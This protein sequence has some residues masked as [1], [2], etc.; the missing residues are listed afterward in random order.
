M[1]DGFHKLFCTIAEAITFATL[2]VSLGKYSSDYYLIYF[3]FITVS[4]IF[5][6]E[7]HRYTV[8]ERANKALRILKSCS[9]STMSTRGKN[10][11]T[12][13]EQKNTTPHL[14][15]RKKQPRLTDTTKLKIKSK[16]KSP[17]TFSNFNSVRRK[18]VTE[19]K[20]KLHVDFKQRSLTR[21][22][23]LL[24]IA[25]AKTKENSKSIPNLSTNNIQQQ[26]NNKGDLKRSP[27]SL[28][29][30][31]EFGT[32]NNNKKKETKYKIDD[33]ASTDSSSV[34]VVV[35][36]NV[37]LR[38]RFKSKVERVVEMRKRRSLPAN[39][40]TSINNNSIN[41]NTNNNNSDNTNNNKNQNEL[42]VH[43]KKITKVSAM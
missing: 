40:A 29:N 20:D 15:G 32:S 31:L 22:K 30:L 37:T 21:P 25:M 43:F 42:N 19:P 35:K 5:G 11:Q 36:K 2:L 12:M 16:L 6:F 9:S 17:K 39:F 41:N 14:R 38:Q 1:E 10:R 7:F 33:N 27:R 23:S 3:V 13:G 34:E 18:N 28:S 24:N 26:K 8:K 4:V